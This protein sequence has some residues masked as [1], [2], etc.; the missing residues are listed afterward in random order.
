MGVSHIYP[1]FMCDL[2]LFF[3]QLPPTLKEFQIV[4]RS[5]LEGVRST[6]KRHLSPAAAISERP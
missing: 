6:R 5:W 4:L 3:R 1:A 2:M